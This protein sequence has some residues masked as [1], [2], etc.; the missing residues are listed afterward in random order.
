[1]ER[2]TPSEQMMGWNEIVPMKE[3]G[4][5]Y[6]T[7]IADLYLTVEVSSIFGRGLKWRVGVMLAI[8]ITR[9]IFNQ[10]VPFLVW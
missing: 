10:I 8:Q 1:M 9:S 4:Y 3:R 5:C 7:F 6:E 2:K